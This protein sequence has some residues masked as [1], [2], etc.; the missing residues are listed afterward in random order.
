MYN[1]S[2]DMLDAS[3]QIWSPWII[4]TIVIYK[5]KITYPS[6]TTH[7]TLSKKKKKTWTKLPR[8]TPTKHIEWVGL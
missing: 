4:P 6:L 1:N 7:P 3:D 8:V 2:F 5:E